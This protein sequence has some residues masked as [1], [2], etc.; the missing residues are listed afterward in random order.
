MPRASFTALLTLPDSTNAQGASNP[1]REC[2]ASAQALMKQCVADGSIDHPNF[3]WFVTNGTSS[4]GQEPA[5]PAA[6]K[7][8]LC[9]RGFTVLN[10]GVWLSEQEPVVGG[11]IYNGM[12]PMV[13]GSACSQAPQVLQNVQTLL[14]TYDLKCANPCRFTLVDDLRKCYSSVGLDESLFL[15]NRTAGQ[16]IGGTEEDVTTFC[17]KREALLDCMTPVHD[18]CPE[19]LAIMSAN[20]FHLPSYK[21]GVGILCKHPKVYLRGLECFKEP[22]N[23]VEKCVQQ[24]QQQFVQTN[25]NAANQN[26]TQAQY[27]E[28]TCRITIKQADCDLK[29]WESKK[30]ED[31]NT[32]T[33][34]LRREMECNLMPPNCTVV[35][36]DLFD[37]T[38]HISKFNEK[39]RQ[40]FANG[41]GSGG[42]SGSGNG[43]SGVVCL[44][45]SLLLFALTFLF[46]VVAKVDV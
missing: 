43:A 30:H 18:S 40:N 46:P 38:C 31:C 41:G 17:S 26:W 6:F 4:N 12:L 37:N 20:D 1:Q 39:D 45:H 24:S 44:S 42:S 9:H 35:Q 8:K 11:C 34:G 32:A 14:F 7:D 2:L 19:A 23:L 13:N 22:T 16:V 33:I 29:A 3:L 36:K 15:S 25:V 10:L 28:A 21:K 5:D 27:V